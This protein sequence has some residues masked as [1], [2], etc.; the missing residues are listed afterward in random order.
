MMPGFEINFFDN[1]V[2]I[3]IRK[4]YIQVAS[5]DCTIGIIHIRIKGII[6]S[7]H[8][9]G[10]LYGSQVPVAVLKKDV[11]TKWDAFNILFFISASYN[12][13]GI[14]SGSSYE[15]NSRIT[16]GLSARS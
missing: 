14:K 13:S 4:E 3:D 6:N 11:L 15:I 16:L 5:A 12:V 7:N 10:I 2:Y 1:E 9:P 8:Q